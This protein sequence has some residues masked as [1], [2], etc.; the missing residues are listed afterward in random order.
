MAARG[1]PSEL[2]DFQIS[3]SWIPTAPAMPNSTSQHPICKNWQ[4]NEPAQP[5]WAGSGQFSQFGPASRANLHEA[6]NLSTDY[7]QMTQCQTTQ[8]CYIPMGQCTDPIGKSR[9]PSNWPPVADFSVLE[10]NLSNFDTWQTSV[11]ANSHV[12]GDC[13]RK[14]ELVGTKGTD[15]LGSMSFQKL[16]ALA[17]A[18]GNKAAIENALMEK[19]C[20]GGQMEFGAPSSS[21]CGPRFP[22]PNQGNQSQYNTCYENCK[23]RGPVK[24][25]GETFI[26]ELAFANNH[27]TEHC[28]QMALIIVPAIFNRSLHYNNYRAGASS[29]SSRPSFDLNSTPRM[30]DAAYGRTVSFQFEPTTPHKTNKAEYHQQKPPVIDL[31][32]DEEPT[33]KDARNKVKMSESSV[34]IDQSSS[35]VSTLLQENHKPDKGGGTDTA[36]LTKTP[37]QKPRRKKHRPKVIIEGQKK[38][39]PK[40]T[41]KPTASQDSTT[42]RKYVRRKGVAN[43]LSRETDVAGLNGKDS[44]SLQAPTGK[45][46]YVR[47]KGVTKPEDGVDKETTKIEDSKASRI[48]RSSCRRTLNFNSDSQT[49]A[50]SSLQYPSLISDNGEPRVDNLN[51]PDQLATLQC[52]Q[53][54]TKKV[55]V[56]SHRELTQSM[57][58]V[59]ENNMV[60]GY[61]TE[62]TRGKCQIIFSNVTHDKETNTVQATVTHDSQSAQR[63]PSGSLCSST[64]LAT[65]RQVRSLKRQTVSASG[66]SEI[67]KRNEMGKYSDFMQAYLPIFSQNVDKNNAPPGLHFPIIY[68]KKRTEK[69]YCVGTS[70]S[71]LELHTLRDS[72]VNQIASVANQGLACGPCGIANLLGTN[73]PANDAI[74]TGRKIYEDLLALG[75]TERIRKKRSKGSTRLRDLASLLEICRQLPPSPSQ[76]A[77][78]ALPS[79]MKQKVEI[80]HEPPT[81]ME[82]LVAETRTVM[83]TKKRT[84]RSLLA[85]STVQNFY[86]Q[87]K[88]AAIPM[89]PPLA[90]T[91]RTI[92][93]VDSIMEQLN[94]LDL[95]ATNEKSEEKRNAFIAYHSH[96]QEQ[97]A[98]VPFQRSG[99]LIPFD[100]SFDEVRRRRPR[101]KVNL[102][103]ETTRVWK[104]LL[105][106]INSEG[107]DGTD[108]EKT[109]WWEEERR[110]FN[111]RAES[112][113]ARM[114]LVQETKSIVAEHVSYGQG[115]PK[116]EPRLNI[117]KQTVAYN[118]CLMKPC[119]TGDR[120]F[121]PWKGSVVDSVVGVF[122]TQN[123]SDHLS[124]SAFM[125]VAA[126]FPLKSQAVSVEL[127]EEKRGTEQICELDRDGSIGLG[128]DI[129]SKS[130]YG[131]RHQV[132][133]GDSTREANSV[134]E[135][136][137]KGKLEGQSPDTSKHDTVVSSEI[138]ANK[139]ISLIEDGK[140]A[141]DAI[142][143]QN[144]SNS[145]TA[146]MTER[147][148]TC[149]LSTSGEPKACVEP[150]GFDSSTSVIKL[151]EMAGTVLHEKYEED[152][153]NINSDVNH[154]HCQL[155]SLA[156]DL[157]NEAHLDKPTYPSDT[158][159]PSSKSTLSDVPNAGSQSTVSDL[160]KENSQFFDSSTNRDICFGDISER[161]SESAFG[162]VFQKVADVCSKGETK[163]SSTNAT[164]ANNDRGVIN[165][166]TFENQN[167][168]VL[169]QSLCEEIY[170][171]QEVPKG[172]IYQ[173][174]LTDIT[175][176]N[177]NAYNLKYPEHIEVNSNKK[178]S[179][180]HRGKTDEG[181]KEKGGRPRKEKEPKVNWDHLRKQ[182]DAGG[183]VR[184]RTANTMDS[185]D[186][187][188]VRCADVNEIA[189]TIKERGMNNMLAERIKDFLNRLVRDHGSIDLEWLRDV[190]P[191]K[192]KEYLLSFRGLGLK[193]VECVRL[194]TLHH[195]AFP[196][197]TNVGRI[198]VRLGWVP[199]Q[200]LPE[201]LQLHLLELY[202][203][204]ESIQKYLWPRLCKLDQRTL[205]ELHYQMIT[206]G[207]VF[208][209]KSKPNCNACPMRGECRHFASAFASARLS[210]PAPED[211]SI[212]S[213]TET[214]TADQNPMRS[215]NTLP[216]P[217]PEA[218]QLS[219]RSGAN[220][221]QPI[222]EEPP[223]PEPIIDVP[224]TPEQDYTQVPQCDIENAFNEDPDEIPTIQLNM[225]E[226]THNLQKIMEQNMELQEGNMSKALVALTSAAASIPVPKLKN[227]SRLRTE[228][229]VYELPDSHP[230]L[231]GM[232]KRE[233]DDPC[234]YLLAIWTPGETANS[235]EPPERRCSSKEFGK[236]CTDEGCSSCNSIREAD[237][238]TVRGTLLIPCR[239]AMR[240][241]FPLNGTYFQVNEVFSD[242]ESSQSPIAVP[243]EWLWNLP[244][245]IVYFGTSIPTIFKGLTTEGIQYCFWRGFVCVRG[246]DRKTR[247]PRPLIARLHFPASRLLSKGKGKMDEN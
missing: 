115:Q 73:P 31:T 144:S 94:Q 33:V 32:M 93:P 85:N 208:C 22:T 35:A 112:F 7:A 80:L 130:V 55:D 26:G 218:N 200:P 196:V 181:P 145:P 13:S 75:P 192:A 232:D 4:P 165:Q 79:R 109:K 89:G 174:N 19:N 210:L 49:I 18:G 72:R 243:R 241:S 244:R 179:E 234:P 142:S 113:I 125:S 37:Q 58:R 172:P 156:L 47:R 110:V 91:W 120:R 98:L 17:N 108:E 104:L 143:S 123:V 176:S 247:A 183:K 150:S 198:A 230:L 159:S 223:S 92:S 39:T 114:H 20:V 24:L 30:A 182:A 235:I 128:D 222:I 65:E 131:D 158:I 100:G 50:G 204:L 118:N 15:K 211:K 6:G 101:P 66:E 69:G 139:S 162:T 70:S 41:K 187:D 220:N 103:D 3:C 186:W 96:Y 9:Y 163:L 216:L 203:V 117:N 213:A 231:E 137:L 45:R 74:Q 160:C 225:E 148:D 63:S 36:D 51:A 240:G 170:N 161:S 71:Q 97:R 56:T 141:E 219:T 78:A 189:E 197:D 221:S 215:M 57:D 64:C 207:K 129:I 5:N 140:D 209:T 21:S 194:L 105:E 34:I 87:Q 10:E 136:F 193:S 67:S 86:N 155:G 205:Y 237:S 76:A 195:L 185:V 116:T 246:F 147:S 44:T 229:Q 1:A 119:L 173:Q 201:S 48:T 14:P 227:V 46:K 177:S 238:Q 212:V 23:P 11:T 206:F 107:I 171:M 25:L 151:L 214:R 40:S 27:Q 168:Q 126:R 138:A 42:V 43:P 153:E 52:G 84:K 8:S 226:F 233:P 127:H 88:S 106:N 178:D 121:S 228:H 111:G 99:A 242:H 83:K 60:G 68:K 2:K 199:L 90:L 175:G 236:L 188:A 166:K 29:I 202:P 157:Q 59:Q 132:F 152:G 95:N 184:A 77:A 82:A 133:E 154:R 81:C 191:D 38:N 167:G 217:S 190:P 134:D 135:F 54:M 62:P 61:H 164:S 16:L 12:Y 122:L 169:P 149:L 102:D 28:E 180:N 245:R 224:A 124:S 239:T 146:Q 53:G